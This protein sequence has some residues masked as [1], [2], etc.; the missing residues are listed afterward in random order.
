MKKIKF[1]VR[2]GE[3]EARFDRWSGKT[4]EKR[5]KRKRKK[6]KESG[7]QLAGR[8]DETAPRLGLVR[9]RRALNRI[10]RACHYTPGE[11]SFARNEFLRTRSRRD[12]GREKKGKKTTAQ[13]VIAR[14]ISAGCSSFRPACPLESRI[15]VITVFDSLSF[16]LHSPRTFFP[17]RTSIISHYLCAYFLNK[18]RGLLIAGIPISIARKINRYFLSYND[19]FPRREEKEGGFVTNAQVQS[20][21]SRGR[22][23]LSNSRRDSKIRR[24]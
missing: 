21:R 12:G 17:F 6:D 5:W 19:N 18:T 22:V 24:A 8:C 11:F 15:L 16:S 2:P 3:K 13:P 4:E 10:P 1:Q 23:Y 7:A 14:R 9:T 20:A